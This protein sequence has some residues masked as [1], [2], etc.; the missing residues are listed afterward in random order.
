MKRSAYAR[1]PRDRAF[2]MFVRKLP[3]AVRVEPPDP[4]RL[5]PCTGRVEADHMGDRAV[6]QKADDTTC[7]PM[8]ATHHVQRTTHWGCFRNLDREQLRGWRARQIARTQA[9][10]SA[11]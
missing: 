5:T 3:C 2:M 11:R 6:G 9:E 8:C 7:V 10:W 1:R 4:L